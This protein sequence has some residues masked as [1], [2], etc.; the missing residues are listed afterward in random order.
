[1]CS[2]IGNLLDNAREAILR[3]VSAGS[4]LDKTIELHIKRVRNMLLIR[5]KNSYS[6]HLLR[7]GNGRFLSSK[8]EGEHGLGLASIEAIV[9]RVHGNWQI[10]TDG[11]MFIV[12]VGLPYLGGENA[13]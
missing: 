9:S 12:T 3:G 8:R 4:P 1:L 11:G 7:D 5:C 10:D 2:V 13:E 6:G